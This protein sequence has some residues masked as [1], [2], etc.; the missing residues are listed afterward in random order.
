MIKK[1]QQTIFKNHPNKTVQLKNK[2]W[3]KTKPRKS[4]QT[5]QS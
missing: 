5:T 3:Q 1:S 2:N 4:S